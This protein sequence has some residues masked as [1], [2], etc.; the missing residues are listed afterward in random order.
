MFHEDLIEPVT[1]FKRIKVSQMPDNQVYLG[2]VGEF[3]DVERDLVREVATIA[4]W[5]RTGGIISI[6]EH[7]MDKYE[8]MSEAFD[9]LGDAIATII[10]TINPKKEE[11]DGVPATLA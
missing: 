2:F 5:S 3:T 11:E 1:D 4:Q 8:P 7:E 10:E 9:A 6:L